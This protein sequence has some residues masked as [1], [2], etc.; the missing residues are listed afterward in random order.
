MLRECLNCLLRRDARHSAPA[1]PSRGAGRRPRADGTGRPQAVEA[2]SKRAR[3]CAPRFAG[4]AV[5]IVAPAIT[6]AAVLAGEYPAGCTGTAVGAA[7]EALI[8]GQP[9]LGP[10]V[11]GDA[12]LYQATLTLF[13][14]SN[15]S[16]Y[17]GQLIVTL[18]NGDPVP[19]AGY[20]GTPDVTPVVFISPFIVRASVPYIASTAD[21][22]DAG[23]LVARIDYGGT[24]LQP[25]QENGI[26]MTDPEVQTATATA[27]L[28]I[29]LAPTG[30]CE[31]ACDIAFLLPPPGTS[32]T[33]TSGLIQVSFGADAGPCSGATGSID[34]G[35]A[36][37]DIESGEIVELH[38]GLDEPPP[39]GAGEGCTPGYWMQPHHFDS[40][41]AP[42]APATPF[43]DL[44]DDAF[45]GLTLLDVLAQGGGGLAALGRH[46]VAALLNAASPGVNY[47]LTAAQVIEAFD[48]VHPGT[49]AAYEALKDQFEALNEQG[50]G[51]NAVAPGATPC[52]AVWDGDVLVIHADMAILV[53]ILEQP[54]VPPVECSLDLC[55]LLSNPPDAAPPP[56]CPADVVT[57]G[58]V[59]GADLVELLLAW[60]P[61]PDG[62]ACDMNGD[63]L[64]DVADLVEVIIAWGGCPDD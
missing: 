3:R 5:A 35:C 42:Y 24:P 6:S 9:T 37:V 17:G 60:G 4:A 44:F 56:P 33:V 19:M 31:I 22:N 62:H 1:S 59:D 28:P 49:N 54:G 15:C 21:V 23:F 18:P 40:W 34:I 61:Q 11:E 39:D 51:L 27:S 64:V 55:A 14:P 36:I 63:L 58:V 2:A 20:P 38:C 12:I 47:G 16:F 57:D 13:G 43:A 26:F 10:V 41:P 7:I 30:D 8:G 46:T 45:P 50:C 48:A 25:E 32:G 53:A 52:G 29:A